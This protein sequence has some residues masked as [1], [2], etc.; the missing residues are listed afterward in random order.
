M[1]DVEQ[2]RLVDEIVE[3]VQRLKMGEL[4]FLQILIRQLLEKK[5]EGLV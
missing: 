5:Q 2:G 3:R 1:T 4:V